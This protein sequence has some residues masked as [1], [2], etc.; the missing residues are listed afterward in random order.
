MI[1]LGHSTGQRER[2]FDKSTILSMTSRVFQLCIFVYLFLEHWREL[3][4]F[5]CL[6]LASCF[7]NAELW[8]TYSSG[9]PVLL[10]QF[11][12][13]AFH[14]KCT[15]CR[16]VFIKVQFSHWK[17]QFQTFVII[18]K[19]M[20]QQHWYVIL[21]SQFIFAQTFGFSFSFGIVK[22]Y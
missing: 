1:S 17:I 7:G 21:A 18:H 15:N 12:K 10:P 8:G 9:N 22:L 3:F 16:L 5:L 13:A 2:C 20:I 6:L 14:V 4:H 11:K 19:L